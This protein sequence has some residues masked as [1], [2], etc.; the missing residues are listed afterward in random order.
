MMV[1]P[2]RASGLSF[3]TEVYCQLLLQAAMTPACTY[4]I[5]DLNYDLKLKLYC[6]TT[7]NI[8]NSMVC[9]RIC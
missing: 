2:D 9:D 7:I 3:A 6:N 4:R 1:E 5:D 8:V